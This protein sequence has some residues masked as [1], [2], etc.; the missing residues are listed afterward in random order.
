MTRCLAPDCQM[1]GLGCDN[2]TVILVCFLHGND[3]KDLCDRCARSRS[4]CY[5]LGSN[6]I[7]LK[8]DQTATSFRVRDS[9]HIDGQG[10][11]VISL[12]KKV[13]DACYVAS[14]C[15]VLFLQCSGQV[16][17][18][19]VGGWGAGVVRGFVER[20][21]FQMYFLGGVRFRIGKWRQLFELKQVYLSGFIQRL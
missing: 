6:S 11:T 7:D 4:S 5:Q 19:C 2:M 8:Q 1:G 9:I 17:A 14:F 20:P 21:A 12:N 3:Y 13:L 16:C 15:Y 10:L 18:E